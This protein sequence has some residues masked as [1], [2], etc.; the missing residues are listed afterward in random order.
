MKRLIDNSLTPAAVV[1]NPKTKATQFY[2]GAA[3]EEAFHRV[4][5]TPRTMALEFCRSWQSIGAEL[6]AK[7][8][9][10]FSPNGE[11]FGSL[12][13]RSEVLAKML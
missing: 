11:D 7:G 8:I 5:L 12:F 4:F 6:R 3:D 13:L 1:Q 9:R 2:I 10:P